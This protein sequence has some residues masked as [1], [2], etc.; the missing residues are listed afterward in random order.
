MIDHPTRRARHMERYTEIRPVVVRD[1]PDAHLL[2]LKVG[3]QSFALSAGG[4]DYH[5][6]KEEAEWAR[7]MLCIALD[8]IAN[9]HAQH[10]RSE[11]GEE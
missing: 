5:D 1:T 10:S 2:F 9:Q 11:A 6:T 3:N 4:Q 8:A 7:D